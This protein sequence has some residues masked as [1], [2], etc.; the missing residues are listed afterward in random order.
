MSRKLLNSGS[1]LDNPGTTRND[2]GALAIGTWRTPTASTRPNWVNVSISADFQWD[3]NGDAMHYRLRAR[4]ASDSSDEH[5]VDEL[6]IDADTGLLGNISYDFKATCF[7][8]IIPI[9]YEYRIEEVIAG[10]A[11]S[12]N[13]AVEQPL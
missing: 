3:S 5:T 13:S 8:G 7:Q 6:H 11:A 4:K 1:F 10:D 2:Q 9:G 12:I